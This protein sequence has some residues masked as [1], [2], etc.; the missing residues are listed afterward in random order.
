[1]KYE[2]SFNG[3]QGWEFRLFAFQYNLREDV[4]LLNR[5]IFMIQQNKIFSNIILL[6]K[7]SEFPSLEIKQ[8]HGIPPLNIYGYLITLIHERV[9]E[10][11]DAI[12]KI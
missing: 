7:K 11:A 9:S 12:L 10:N 8:T 2:F 4:I 6:C 3:N 1:M 5:N